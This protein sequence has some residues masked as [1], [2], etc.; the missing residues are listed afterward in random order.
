VSWFGG[1]NVSKLA[2]RGDVQKLSGLLSAESWHVQQA[3]AQA[4]ARLKSRAALRALTDAASSRDP[5]TGI[6]RPLPNLRAAAALASLEW[7][8]TAERLSADIG[9]QAAA[10]VVARAAV[11]AWERA[12]RAGTKAM[13]RALRGLG[14]SR[15]TEI[16]L[17]KVRDTG[18]ALEERYA[19]IVLLGEMRDARAVAPLLAVIDEPEGIEYTGGSPVSNMLTGWRNRVIGSLGRI[20]DPRAADKVEEYLD[21]HY[22]TAA[23]TLAELGRPFDATEAIRVA[24]YTSRDID[25]RVEAIRFLK[26]SRDPSVPA[27]LVRLVLDPDDEPVRNAAAKELSRLPDLSVVGLLVAAL[28]EPHLREGVQCAKR[29]LNEIITRRVGELTDDDLRAIAELRDG[30]GLESE[31][32]YDSYEETHYFRTWEHHM[33]FERLRERARQELKQRRGS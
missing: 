21:E 24:E 2:Q 9:E 11:V 25:R 13:V 14:P 15:I 19:A 4:L 29:V 30:I 12:D 26:A 1:R 23:W 33:S 28:A 10:E 32:R 31:M 5:H 18:L 27:A 17:P 6:R 20:G 22:W 3:A 7:K 16:L 8:P